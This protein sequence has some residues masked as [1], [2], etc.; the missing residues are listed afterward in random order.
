MSTL[1]YEGGCHC[2]NVRYRVSG[3]A[4]DLCYCHCNSCRRTSGAPFVAW[5]TFPVALFALL[6][7]RLHEYRSSAPVSRGFCGSCG[8]SL[9][10][11]NAKRP[12]EIDVTLAS[13]D[14]P[15][16]LEPEFHI[17]TA[18]RLPWVEIADGLPQFER[19]RT[20]T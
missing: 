14:D 16:A 2:G 19:W 3:D 5:G 9:T 6:S 10:Y 1:T 18:E 20:Q 11:F 7:G 8:T 13:L 15:A 17:W 4:R 12:D